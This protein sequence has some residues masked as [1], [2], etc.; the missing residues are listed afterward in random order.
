MKR[1]EMILSALLSV[2]LLAGCGPGGAM[3]EA[4]KLSGFL[5]GRTYTMSAEITGTVAQVLVDQGQ[6][7]QGGQLLLRLD[8][9]YLNYER[10]RATAALAAAQAALDV[11]ENLPGQA[12]IDAQQAA[13]M[14]AS[15]AL[16]A[17]ND[18]MDLLRAAYAPFVPPGADL[19]AAEGE[20]ALAQANLALEQATLEQILAGAPAAERIQAR[21]VL[22][23]AEI[24]LRLVDLQLARMEIH[25]PVDGVVRQVLATAG[26]AVIAGT[27]LA[28]ITEEDSLRL[29]VYL[30]AD[31]LAAVSIGDPARLSVD[32]Y[33]GEEFFGEVVR[34][35]SQAQF[36]PSEVQT[37]EE[38]V[39]QV[40]AI[41]IEVE[42]SSG[43]LKAGMPADAVLLDA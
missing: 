9:T 41:E 18:R 31:Q 43:R 15:A 1:R 3:S 17:A 28:M 2:L 33:P 40:F 29:T 24:A 4:G 35:A 13:V 23:Q 26:T 6:A 34:I 19:H 38:R 20:V 30:P 12:V 37:R 5:E 14:G 39:K 27:P 16:Q 36:T 22:A 32:A 11:L 25:S 21:A 42:D 7:V 10:Q 8:P